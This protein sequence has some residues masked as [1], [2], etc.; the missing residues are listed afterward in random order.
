MS[1]T[2]GSSLVFSCEI[3][4]DVDMEDIGRRYLLFFFTDK[5]TNICLSYDAAIVLIPDWIT[6][7]AALGGDKFVEVLFC[8]E[9]MNGISYCGVDKTITFSC[10]SRDSR[11]TTDITVDY[12]VVE[13]P[14]RVMI[15]ELM[16]LTYSTR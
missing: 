10:C 12:I 8:N 9:G 13:G 15:N 6:F 7:V 3:Y 2:F 4:R 11:C 14:L 16:N 5:K 1:L